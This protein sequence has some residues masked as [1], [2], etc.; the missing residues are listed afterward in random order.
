MFRLARAFNESLS[1]DTT[2]VTDMNGKSSPLYCERGC[3]A[4]FFSEPRQTERSRLAGVGVK[5]AELP[6]GG[7]ASLRFRQ[8]CVGMFHTA[9]SF[10]KPIS[11]VTTSVTNMGSEGCLACSEAWRA[12]W[13][14]LHCSRPVSVGIQL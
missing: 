9:D 11:F 3:A 10:D 7:S 8:R 2:S 4:S 1:F 13:P 6:D 5:G 14:I 12:A